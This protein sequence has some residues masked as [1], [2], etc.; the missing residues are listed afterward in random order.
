MLTRQAEPRRK[1]NEVTE[2]LTH[3]ATFPSAQRRYDQ[4][5]NQFNVYYYNIC[6]VR[7]VI[8]SSSSS[9]TST[10]IRRPEDVPT[11]D[12]TVQ[13][14]NAALSCSEPRIDGKPAPSRVTCGGAVLALRSR[15]AIEHTTFRPTA[16]DHERIASFLNKKVKEGKLLT[17]RWTP[18]GWIGF[19][20][21]LTMSQRYIQ[22]EFPLALQQLP[23]Y[24]KFIL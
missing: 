16:Y 7:F 10:D 4:W 8:Q 24:F 13:C 19:T 12:N 5:R 18:Q 15:L 21:V 22:V 3:T 11:G 23:T 6:K 2:H 14:L 9:I 20:V 17:G 1:A